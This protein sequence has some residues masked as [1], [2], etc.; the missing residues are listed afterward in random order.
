MSIAPSVE[1]FLL[2]R[3]VSYDIVEHPR[4]Y[5][6]TFTA[7]LAHVPGDALAK[8]VLLRDEG[9]GNFV[10]AVLPA[11]CTAQLGILEV[12]THRNLELASELEV[13]RTFRDC[14]LGAVPPL[15]EAYGLDTIVD[16]TIVRQDEV[17][18]EAGDHTELVHVTGHEFRRLMAGAEV[19]HFARHV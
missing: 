11:T 18:F 19:V 5:D 14:A 1:K 4:T 17:Y 15:G 12:A 10:L 16:D 9:D 7:A 6:A 2:E 8:S 3:G 13:G